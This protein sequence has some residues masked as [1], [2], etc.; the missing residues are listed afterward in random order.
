MPVGPHNFTI[1]HVK[2]YAPDSISWQKENTGRTGFRRQVTLPS[3]VY[4]YQD[5]DCY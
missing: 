4:A 1:S 2:I 3:M 5:H